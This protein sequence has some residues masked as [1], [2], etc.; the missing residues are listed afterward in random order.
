MLYNR[1]FRRR[2]IGQAAASTSILGANPIGAGVAIAG[3]LLQIGNMIDNMITNSGCGATCIQAS[4]VVNQAEPLLQQNLAAYLALPQP[5]T[6]ADQSQALAN[7]AAVWAVVNNACASPTLGTAGANCIADRISGACNYKTSPGGWQQQ[8]NGVWTY[9]YPGANGSG[10]TC[11]NW[12]VGYHDPIANDPTVV[13][14][15]ST[16]TT[17]GTTAV[18]STGCLSLLTPFG[19]P[20]PCIGPIGGLTAAGLALLLAVLL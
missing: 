17:T 9:V 15:S 3:G 2:G 12:F 11:W 6:T 14:G 4:N 7:F 16:T 8:Q 18:T 10:S 5:H 20:D 1:P 13:A 19:I